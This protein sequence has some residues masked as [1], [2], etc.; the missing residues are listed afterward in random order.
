MKKISTVAIATVLSFI[1]YGQDSTVQMFGKIVDANKNPIANVKIV[2]K[3]TKYETMTNGE[4]HYFF[5]IPAKK[6]VLVY[7]HSGYETK[8]N[9]FT[10]TP[11]ASDLYL[12]SAKKEQ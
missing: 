8:E 11:Q 6:G 9:K 12:V 5:M 7:S 1:A 4:G 3:G 10:G 2:L